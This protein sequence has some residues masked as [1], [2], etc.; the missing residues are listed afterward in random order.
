MCGDTSFVA[1]AAALGAV[2]TLNAHAIAFFL[3]LGRS[4]E[5]GGIDLDNTRPRFLNVRGAAL[6]RFP[7]VVKG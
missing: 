7:K 2:S 1:E 6:L 4:C 5:H 3:S